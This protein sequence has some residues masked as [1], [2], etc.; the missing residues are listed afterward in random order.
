MSSRDNTAQEDLI[1]RLRRDL[2]GF[3]RLSDRHQRMMAIYIFNEGTPRRMHRIFEDFSTFHYRE[4]ERDFGRGEFSR[5]NNQ[6]GIFEVTP[7]WHFMKNSSTY[8]QHTATKGY[9]LTEQVARIRASYLKPRFKG[10]TRLVMENGN[11][12]RTAPNPIDTKNGGGAWRN[13][14]VLNKIPVDVA[15]LRGIH[16]HL[17][18][19][20]REKMQTDLFAS[21]TRRNTAY[22]IDSIEKL[23]DMAR[24]DVAG[25]GYILHRYKPSDS[26]R[27]YAKGLSLQSIPKEI[28]QAALHGLHEYDF[29]NCHYAIFAQMA[30]AY[31]H[32]CQ[33][34]KHY[35]ANKH[36]VREGIAH[37][38]GISVNAAKKCLLAIMYGARTTEWHENAIPSVIG[39]QAANLYRDKE[40][41][42]IASDI[43]AGRRTIIDGWPKRRT[44][45]LNDMGQRIR[46]DE[47]AEKVLA[48]L[49]QG[50][51]AK[52]L[53]AAIDLNPDD[54]VL[55]M[56]DGFITT[57]L[58]DASAVQ[59]LVAERTGYDLP[60]SYEHIEIPPDLG[61]MN[62]SEH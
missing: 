40:F 54:V 33:A 24:T 53:R 62:D 27:L 31:G 61:L 8:L 35:V 47:S 14:K 43:K 15:V 60:L 6:L 28:R 30:D 57:R 49:I 3:R 10:L 38:V 36:Q 39:N 18:H 21:P 17:C 12:Q 1:K 11:I 20:Q 7:N 22:L 59:A 50:V 23:L 2:R 16:S 29:E 55:L 32:N 46:F 41:A 37:R 52:A 58:I 56:H 42:G 44:T 13:A 9:R 5:I 4:L 45:L 25:R 51:E 26:G 34:I 19:F 48:H